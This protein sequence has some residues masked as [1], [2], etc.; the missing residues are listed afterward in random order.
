MNTCI[1]ASLPEKLLNRLLVIKGAVRKHIL[2][3]KQHKQTLTTTI[4]KIAKQLCD[5]GKKVL[6]VAGDT[7]RAAAADLRRTWQLGV[8]ALYRWRPGWCR[9]R[10][11]GCSGNPS[12]Y[13]R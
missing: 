12:I 4:G 5:E 7:F 6:L 8:N 9:S 2:H 13:D 1:T 11:C 10:Y 3:K